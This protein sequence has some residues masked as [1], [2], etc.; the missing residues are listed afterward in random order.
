MS[1]DLYFF[2]DKFG[3]DP[4]KSVWTFF[5]H[6]KNWK[7]DEKNNQAFYENLDTGAYFIANYIARGDGKED[8]DQ[9]YRY[10]QILFNVNYYRPPFFGREAALE[11]L[12]FSR[13]FQFD[14]L[15][16]QSRGM[17]EGEAGLVSSDGVLR[18]WDHGNV[19]A[20]SVISQQNPDEKPIVA[21]ER[22]IMDAWR[23]NFEAKPALNAEFVRKGA[24]VFVAKASWA[25]HDDRPI[26]TAVWGDGCRTALPPFID[27][28]VLY[29]D[30]I[31]SKNSVLGRF[32]PRKWKRQFLLCPPQ[33]LYALS[34]VESARAAD[35]DFLMIDSDISAPSKEVSNFYMRPY[36]NV[37][38]RKFSMI[39]SD[40]VLSQDIIRTA[41]SA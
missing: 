8:T 3:K 26:L 11:I 13:F 12:A 32:L 4:R 22:K 36:P 37:S 16:P 9:N 21:A 23:W 5:Q 24:D 27:A 41:D 6:R 18:G 31:P 15:D 19:F 28:V 14:F 29:A 25:L 2:A 30:K 1:Y 33:D 35:H 34:C 38:A 17:G 10:P 20:Y 40:M 7:V 39:S